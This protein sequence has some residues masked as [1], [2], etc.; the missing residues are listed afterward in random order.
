M[1]ANPFLRYQEKARFVQRR[2]RPVSLAETVRNI[3]GIRKSMAD[4]EQAIFTSAETDRAVGYQVVAR[5]PG[6]S[7][8]DAR[9][10]AVWGP[11]HDSLLELGPDAVSLNF[12]PLPS[13][14]YCISRTT[15]AG[16]EYSGRGGHRIYTH[17]L[18]VSAEVLGRFGNNPFALARAAMAAG[19][20]EVHPRI[21]ARLEPVVLGGG[22]TPVD[23]AL[24][25]RLAANPGPERMAMLV[26]MVCQST[27]L[28]VA[29]APSAEQLIAG[30]FN[31]LPPECRTEFSFATGLKFSSRRPFR[32]VALSD[33]KAEQRW[34]SH[35]PNV[36]LL[37][38][39]EE[40]PIASVSMDGWARLIGRVLASGH[41]SFLATELAKRRFQLTLDD[42]PALGLQMIED[43]EATALRSDHEPV[44]RPLP[45]TCR[46]R[47]EDT[48]QDAPKGVQCAHAAH[49]RFEKSGA[50][51][52]TSA[53]PKEAAPSQA[54]NPQS[55]EVLQELERLDD[56]VY[57]AINGQEAA[58][59]EV[60]TLWPKILEQLGDEL[61]AESRAQYLRYALS[62]WEECAQGKG[63]RNPARAVQALD[64]LCVLFNET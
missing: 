23:Q 34:V 17:C 4:V 1:P 32:I 8:D 28:A 10:L 25:A 3:P 31:C 22:A 21:P 27:C 6:V 54:L 40:V 15:P 2:T 16:W 9:Q 39:R 60:K 37:E 12:F 64:V 49:S 19:T 52:A 36:S 61:L 43:F 11:S 63:V 13:G 57:E 50:A 42:L 7:D 38:L 58:L 35:Q 62:I 48:P 18:I 53:R 29:G 56:I 33:D 45:T 14:A 51:A 5:S 46:P 30:L 24:L 55:A 59:I 41:T 44:G 26:H 20:L 47:R